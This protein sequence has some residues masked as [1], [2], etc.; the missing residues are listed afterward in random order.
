MKK[1]LVS[2]WKYSRGIRGYALGTIG[3][4]IGAFLFRDVLRPFAMQHVIDALVP[5]YGKTT[6]DTFE[7]IF[8][9]GA[10]AV[11]HLISQFFFR[12]GEFSNSKFEARHMNILRNAALEHTIKHSLSFFAETFTGSIVTKQKRYVGSAELLFDETVGQYLYITVQIIGIIF[13]IFSISIPIACGIL[14]WTIGYLINI[15]ITAK[16]RLELDEI[17]ASYDSKVTGIFADIIGNISVVKMFGQHQHEQARFKKATDEHEQALMTSWNFS[18]WQGVVQGIFSSI[19]HLG[20]LC[21]SVY[22]CI[23]GK[24]TVGSVMLIT[25]YAGQLS[26]SLWDFGRSIKRSSRAIGDAKEMLEIMNEDA[27]IVIA[28]GA[29][30]HPTIEPHECTIKFNKVA[31][32]YKNGLRV[33]KD[34]DLTIP[35]GQKVAFIGSTGA[36]KTTLVQLLLRNVDVTDGSITIG[37]YNIKTSVTPDGLKD[38]ISCVSQNIDLFY[39]SL[40]DNIAYGRPSASRAEIIEAAR[41]ARIHDFIITL[42]EG[43][44][45]KVGEHGVKLSGGQRQRIAIARAL[46][47]NAP[48]LILDEATSALDNVT[49]KE[50]QNILETGLHNKTVIVIAH[51]LTTIRNCDRIIVLNNGKIA[52]DGTHDQLVTDTSD[53]GIY[54]RLLNSHEIILEE[55]TLLS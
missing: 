18:N 35:A 19:I 1:L 21:T 23:H 28:P 40:A 39:L 10:F 44:D 54:H 9:V 47:H 25:I 13:V 52:Q 36:G 42:E 5:V 15:K 37:P 48:I 45:T 53:K 41:K 17:A 33:F 4:F 30:E 50:I 11:I 46:L 6:A 26:G 31:F 34:F 22:F 3:L 7:V 38:L 14:I 55:E 32:R 51:R 43:Y 29:F 16:R 2:Y 8:Y 20:T 12:G 24:I 49:E 27:E